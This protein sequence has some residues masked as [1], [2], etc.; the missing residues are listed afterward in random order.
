MGSDGRKWL[1]RFDPRR[2]M[3][4]GRMDD[5]A[6]FVDSEVIKTKLDEI[7]ESLARIEG[8]DDAIIAALD[9]LSDQ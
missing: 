2:R 5:P 4:F 6:D 8:R 1:M 3:R 9:A 7:L